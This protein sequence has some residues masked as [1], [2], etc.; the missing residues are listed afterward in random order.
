[1]HNST[2]WTPC[3]IDYPVLPTPV[4]ISERRVEN[5]EQAHHAEL[6]KRGNRVKVLPRKY[7]LCKVCYVCKGSKQAS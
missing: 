1:M 5:S 7:Y 3:L 2:L 4:Y 6:H